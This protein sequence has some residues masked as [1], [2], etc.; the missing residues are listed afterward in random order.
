M[1]T[2]QSHW[3]TISAPTC[4]LGESPLWDAER[5]ILYYVDITGKR[6]FSFN[7][8]TEE[9]NT[10]MLP[11]M[12]GCLALKKDGSLLA[13]MEDGIYYIGADD[14]TLAHKAIK[15][16]G[17][18]FNDGK[19][20]PDGRFYVGTSSAENI[21]RLYVLEPDGGIRVLL[22]G[23]GISNGLDWS[24]DGKILYYID[25][26]TG[27]VDAFDFDTAKGSISNRRTILDVPI[28]MGSPDGMTI[29]TEGMLWIALWG[30]SGIVRADPVSGQILE[31]YPIDAPQTSCPVFAGPDLDRVIVTSSA[32][33][34]DNAKYPQTGRT[35]RAKLHV[36]GRV[37]YRFG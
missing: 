26:R 22:E 19:P 27:K 16:A 7:W 5:G 11:Q 33:G 10:R 8:E 34:T 1:K 15:I 3:E 14:L 24:E 35:F 31:Y 9:L 2:H 21:G 36:R 17:E 32:D 18:R 20:G 6:L 37:P 4:L 25:T 23:V 28:Q 13:A 12:A 30:G 29:D